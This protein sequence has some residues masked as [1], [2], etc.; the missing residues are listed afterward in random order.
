MPRALPLLA[1]AAAACLCGC[2]TTRADDP[3]RVET[4]SQA[5][6]ENVRGAVTAP[7]R[8][9]N[10]LRTKIPDVLLEAMADPYRRPPH[11]VSCGDLAGLLEPLDNA[12][13]ADLDAPS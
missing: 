6:R 8:D 10:V 13:G 1:I 11:Q 5:E 9:F 3:D 4:T 2:M 7:L 12:L